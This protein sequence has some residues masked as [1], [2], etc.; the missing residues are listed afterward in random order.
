MFKNKCI[1]KYGEDYFCIFQVKN[2]KF[3]YYFA[4]NEPFCKEN[5]ELSLPE[6]SFTNFNK[7]S[8]ILPDLE[9]SKNEKVIL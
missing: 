8:Q 9:I 5:I 2:N 4:K 6:S 7:N 3:L 1:K